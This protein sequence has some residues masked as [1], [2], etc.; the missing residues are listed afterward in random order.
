MV[1]LLQLFVLIVGYKVL[2]NAI[3]WL[4]CQRYLQLYQEYLKKPSH[5]FERYSPRIKHLLVSAGLTDVE[6]PVVEPAGWGLLSTG[7]VSVL[8]NLLNRRQDIV[9][10]VVALLN[11]AIGVYWNRMI[12]ALSPIYWIET[13]LFLPKRVAGFIG[14]SPETVFTKVTQVLYWLV[15]ALSSFLYSLYR[16]EIDAAVRKWLG[17]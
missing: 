17:N 4:H 15:C 10:V 5:E 16:V 1:T 9:G 8:D 12:E 7:N 11:R 3:R 13:V 2:V 6:R 14:L